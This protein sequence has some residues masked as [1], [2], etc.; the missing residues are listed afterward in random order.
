MLALWLLALPLIGQRPD[1]Q[2]SVR[3]D[4][5][6]LAGFLEGNTAVFLGVPFAAPPTGALRWKPSQSVPPWQG[7]RTATS[8]GAVCPQA[9]GDPPWI[10]TRFDEIAPHHRYYAGPVRMDEDCLNLNVWTG[11]WTSN[12]AGGRKLP[13]M[14]WIHGGSNIGGTG[15]LPPFGPSLAAKGV[16]FVSFNYRLGA[17]GFLAHPDLSAESPRHVSGNYAILDQIAALQWVQRN[18]AA[19]GGDPGNVTIFGESAGGTMVCYLMASPLAR[20]LFHRAILQSCTCRDYLSP[21][22]ARPIRYE[23]G[24]GTSE[25]AGIALARALA[26]DSGPDALRELRARPAADIVRLSENHRE[27]LN[28]LYSGGTVD[29]WVLAEQ[30]AV[31]FAHGRQAKVPVLLGSNADEG[32]VTL[33]NLG[34]LTLA[35]YRAWLR[36]MFDD[37]ADEVFRAYPASGDAAV[38][39]AYLR[40]TADYLRS[41]TVRSLARDTVRAGER[42]Y[43][44]YFD[45][46]SRGAYAREGLGAFHGL[47][48]SFMGG[49][50]FRQAR[51]GSPDRQD[52]KLAET[53]TAYWTQFA[54]AGDPNRRGLPGWPP[55][56]DRDL[57]LELGAHIRPVPVPHA[58]R[59]AVWER[60]LESRL[61]QITGE[62]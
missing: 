59:F 22:L 11:N 45:Y 51:W 44:Y 13:V 47:E 41:Q 30:P 43:L 57:A 58:E 20:G 29:G 36:T 2:A 35:N 28:Y 1:G 42:A 33:G 49:G 56:D 25:D 40:L 38:R 21:E 61:R 12:L 14:V 6:V 54:V 34:E 32:T 17:L 19:F 18:I 60:M 9:A 48:Q 50:Y 16:V 46:P 52:L 26:V 5:G 3:V 39:A 31:T 24:R 7:A 62:R 4:S 37:Y 55:Y 10:E 53:M 8:F 27:V 23:T 15:A